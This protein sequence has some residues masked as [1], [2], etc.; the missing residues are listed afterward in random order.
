MVFKKKTGIKPKSSQLNP[1]TQFWNQVEAKSQSLIADLIEKVL[2][3]SAT[4]QVFNLEKDADYQ[5]LLED[6]PNSYQESEEYQE[7]LAK[8]S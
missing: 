1:E 2:P 4:P 6:L 8:Q 7:K 3:I 5:N